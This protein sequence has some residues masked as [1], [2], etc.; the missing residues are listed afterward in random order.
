MR[1]PKIFNTLPT[2]HS[3]AVCLDPDNLLTPTERDQFRIL[4]LS[5]NKVF[6]RQFG[7]YNG[8]SGPYKASIC[9]GPV[10]PPC[11]KPMLPLYP[12]TNMKVLQDEAD[13][14]EGSGVLRRPEDLGIE[15]KFTS[16]SFL[17]KK[18]DGTCHSFQ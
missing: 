5:Y 3:D 12:Q 14:L 15:V 11:T 18:P 16:P 7:T 4:N 1:T 9:L 8:A 17:R 10:E 2:R 13:K 6:N